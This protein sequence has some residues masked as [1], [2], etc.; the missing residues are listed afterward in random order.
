MSQGHLIYFL[1]SS[2][3]SGNRGTMLRKGEAVAFGQ[4]TY[5][6]L[7]QQ[8][9]SSNQR[10]G[11]VASTRKTNNFRYSGAATLPNNPSSLL[12]RVYMGHLS[13]TLYS[14]GVSA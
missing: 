5:W 4:R 14:N 6:E 7:F 11:F 1:A 2:W 9:S 13:V 10:F 3:Y 8:V 12:Y